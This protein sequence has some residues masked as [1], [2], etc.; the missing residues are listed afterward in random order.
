MRMIVPKTYFSYLVYG[1]KVGNDLNMGILYL[2]GHSL[3]S[4]CRRRRDVEA[5]NGMR[6]RRM[7][8]EEFEAYLEV[9]ASTVFR[10]VGLFAVLLS[11]PMTEYGLTFRT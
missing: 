5:T 10:L 6:L 11:V 8:S 2:K 4:Q 3:K 1:E 7:Y 9:I